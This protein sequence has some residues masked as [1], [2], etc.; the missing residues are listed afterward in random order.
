VALRENKR[1]LKSI[2]VKISKL[3][4]IRLKSLRKEVENN[5]A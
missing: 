2:V 1:R 4:K 5:G 3:K